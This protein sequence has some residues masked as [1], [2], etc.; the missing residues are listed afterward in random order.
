MTKY[1]FTVKRGDSFGGVQFR[2]IRNGQALDLTGSSIKADFKN[3][4]SG[5]IV[6]SMSNANGLIDII[7]PEGGIFIFAPQIIS[8]QSGVYLYDVQITFGDGS[9]KTYIEGTM[10]VE[11][12]ITE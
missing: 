1:D 10:K 5:R 11:Q 3:R 7:Y 2:I 8:V 4:Q 12:D 6:L 9:V